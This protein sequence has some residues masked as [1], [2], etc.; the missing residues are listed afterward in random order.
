MLFKTIRLATMIALVELSMA[1]LFAFQATAAQTPSAPEMGGMQESPRAELASRQREIE[2]IAV[3]L[4]ESF[5]AI[6]DA[7]DTK[8]Y[9][10]NKAA[11]KAHEVDVKL[12]RHAVREYAQ[13][14]GEYDRRCD[15]TGG[16]EQA[17]VYLEDEMK[18]IYH[19]IIESFDDFEQANNQPDNPHIVVT[20]S[21]AEAFAEHRNA[22]RELAG[23]PTV[24]KRALAQTASGCQ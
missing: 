4:N 13:A 17:T 3:K 19:D 6:S 22:L 12:L 9:V 15:V 1:P 10:R 21:V 24:N 11:L 16:Q 5:Q 14:L 8:G 18:G 23:L 20:K 2:S 7:R